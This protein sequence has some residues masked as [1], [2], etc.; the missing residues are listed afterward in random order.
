MTVSLRCGCAFFLGKLVIIKCCLLLPESVARQSSR[1]GILFLYRLTYPLNVHL[2]QS[3][4]F[5]PFLLTHQPTHGSS[6]TALFWQ[7][8]GTKDKAAAYRW[9][10]AHLLVDRDSSGNPR[11][12]SRLCK[13]HAGP[14]KK[15]F[16]PL[17]RSFERASEKNGSDLRVPVA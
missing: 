16:L 2:I 9:R 5:A 15:G 7:L 12:N 1:W 14:Q 8:E 10:L 6:L 3:R 4:L 13:K 11:I 17:F